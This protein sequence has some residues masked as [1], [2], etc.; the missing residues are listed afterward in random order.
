MVEL[1]LEQ[2]QAIAKARARAAIRDRT[3]AQKFDLE[4]LDLSRLNRSERNELIRSGVP[5]SATPASDPAQTLLRG[6]MLGGQDEL[7]G[8]GAGSAQFLAN[9]FGDARSAI[10]GQPVDPNR[11]TAGEAFSDTQQLALLEAQQFGRRAPLQNFAGEFLG[12]SALGG[13]IASKAIGG[14]KSLVDAG[15][16]SAKAAAPF[17]VVAGA[18]SD[19]SLAERGG[20]A[21]IGGI[22]AGGLG[23]GLP[24]V[25]TGVSNVLASRVGQA[26][27]GT[28]ERAATK[29]DNA[30]FKVVRNRLARDVGS[31][32][33][34][35]K[36]L[37]DWKKR[38][39]RD[40]ELLDLGGENM[41]VFM[42]ELAA[43]NP[44]KALQMANRFKAA[45]AESLGRETRRLV[46]NVDPDETIEAVRIAKRI[47]SEPRYNEA[48]RVEIPVDVYNAQFRELLAI[49][50]VKAGANRANKLLAGDIAEAVGRRDR[51]LARD[52][53]STK[54][55]VENWRQGKEVVL[56]TRAMDYITRG[57]RSLEKTQRRSAPD[58]ARATGNVARTIRD[59]LKQANPAFED[60]T[61]F[62]SNHQRAEDVF[63][64]GTEIFKKPSRRVAE[65]VAGL[66][67]VDR[68]MYQLGISDA[69][70]EKLLQTRDKGNKASFL[71]SEDL[72][73]R[74]QA[75][76]RGS[77]DEI[78]SFIEFV[79]LSEGR[80]ERVGSIQRAAGAQTQPRQEGAQA[81]R[82]EITRALQS[83]RTTLR[84]AAEAAIDAPTAAQ[85]KK[86]S[87]ALGEILFGDDVL[88]VPRQVE[89]SP[90]PAAFAAPLAPG[91]VGSGN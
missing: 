89:F 59:R 78:E 16:R 32:R 76:F 45:Q 19:G 66:S 9:R 42:T 43:E 23:F 27:S 35:S 56:D 44:E 38:G 85:N 34:A 36:Q 1:T 12:G 41:R 30:V 6:L 65:E 91:L 70:Q 15:V 25:A 48:Y 77:D 90:R 14:A 46:R 20:N 2:K 7:Q 11:R 4:G 60:A 50:G 5:V 80:F 68:E 26:A 71:N 75:A 73:L 37:A 87:E 57:L 79:R 88:P 39:S 28:L 61:A 53:R 22:A 29:I 10:T 83:P 18:L 17:G 67:D 63:E 24:F 58:V 31:K 33:E 21:A 40:E 47:Q 54:Q 81:V 8:V 52:L 64:L 69:V 84:R 82:G 3:V 74:F 55:L 62:F 72:R 13:P 86:V 49:D 51:E